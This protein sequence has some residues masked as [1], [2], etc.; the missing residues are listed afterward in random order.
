VRLRFDG[1]TGS[2]GTQ[3]AW[4]K[5]SFDWDDQNKNS[6]TMNI[7]EWAYDN[8]GA[9]IKVGD[10]GTVPTPATPLLTLLGLGAMGV[11]A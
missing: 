2:M 9:P 10:T 4:V 3:Y 11:Q 7:V 1:D 5:V 8:S 6:L